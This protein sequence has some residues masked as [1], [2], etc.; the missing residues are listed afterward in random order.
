MSSI[1]WFNL[2]HEACTVQ[3]DINFLYV[4]LK[5]KALSI[6]IPSKSTS[7]DSLIV[8]DP[9]FRPYFKR[10]FFPNIINWNFPGFSF[11]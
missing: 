2:K 6:V 7:S 5:F 3:C 8:I 4:F 1:F 10:F 11:S 9:I